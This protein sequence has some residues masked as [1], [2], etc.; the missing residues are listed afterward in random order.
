MPLKRSAMKR[1]RLGEKQ[2]RLKKRAGTKAYREE[3]WKKAVRARDGF[4]CQFPGCF[5]R[6]KSID[7]HHIAMRSR[8]PDLIFTVANG[9][10]LCRQHHSWCH[11]NSIEATAM[12]LLSDETYEAANKQQHSIVEAAA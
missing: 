1:S 7:A 2:K 5:V 8:R 12:G 6:D 11:L 9:I 3:Q 4:Q 10:A